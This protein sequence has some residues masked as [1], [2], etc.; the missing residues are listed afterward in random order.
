MNDFFSRI[1]GS[2]YGH[3]RSAYYER[4]YAS[5]KEKYGITTNFGFNGTDI[6][7]YGEG[8]LDL[9]ENSY[10]GTNSTIELNKGNKVKIGKECQISHNV[11]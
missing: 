1:L 4:R 9:G 5:Y 2:L 3:I 10:I 11:K 6:R 8:I 7:V